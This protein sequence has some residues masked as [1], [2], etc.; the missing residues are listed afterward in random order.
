LGRADLSGPDRLG[1]ARSHPCVFESLSFRGDLPASLVLGN[2]GSAMDASPPP[3]LPA[4]F[5]AV[6]GAKLEMEAYVGHAR[7]GFSVLDIAQRPGEPWILT[8][9]DVLGQ[10]MLT[11]RLTPKHSLCQPVQSH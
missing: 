2:S 10:P 5:Q 6:P 1:H 11:C 8:Q 4:D 3:N 7:F 9:Y